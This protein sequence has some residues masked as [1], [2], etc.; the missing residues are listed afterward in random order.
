MI[1]PDDVISSVEDNVLNREYTPSAP[2][3]DC[4]E[5]VTILL[6]GGTYKDSFWE[7]LLTID[8]IGHIL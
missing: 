5:Q 4:T 1:I 6:L 3:G 8:G 7:L 2:I